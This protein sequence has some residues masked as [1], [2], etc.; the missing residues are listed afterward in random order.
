[1]SILVSV[2]HP[3]LLRLICAAGLPGLTPTGAMLDN[4]IGQSL[5]KADVA[6][7]LFRLKPFMLEDFFTL[8][9]KFAVE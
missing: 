2:F 7:S 6:S 9:L 1:M 4:P 8:R 3:A 5:F